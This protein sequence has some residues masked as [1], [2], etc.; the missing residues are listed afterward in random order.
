MKQ[1][2]DHQA[3]RG[4]VSSSKSNWRLVNTAT[5]QE[6]SMLRLIPFNFF[7]DTLGNDTECIL[8][9]SGGDID[10][11]DWLAGTLEDRVAIQSNPDKLDKCTNRQLVIS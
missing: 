5:L 3:H 6:E 4:V 8:G 9:K 2:S 7:I 1:Q 11:V 10:L